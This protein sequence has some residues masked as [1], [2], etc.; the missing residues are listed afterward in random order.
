MEDIFTT[1]L[2]VDQESISFHVVFDEEK[3]RF[4]PEKNINSIREFYVKRDHDQWMA[5]GPVNA[6]IKNQ[7]IDNLEEYLLKQ[8]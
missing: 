1:Q 5:E 6:D 4:I 7:A 8:L 2:K 3:Y